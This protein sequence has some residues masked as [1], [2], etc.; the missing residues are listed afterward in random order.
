M[1]LDTVS[2]FYRIILKRCFELQ[3]FVDGLKEEIAAVIYIPSIHSTLLVES[4]DMDNISIIFNG[5]RQ[6]W[7]QQVAFNVFDL[8]KLSLAHKISFI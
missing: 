5:D 1:L 8:Y 4:K 3:W 2:D 7:I 6:Y